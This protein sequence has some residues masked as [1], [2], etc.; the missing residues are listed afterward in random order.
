MAKEITSL[1][2][3]LADQLKDLYSAETLITKALPKLAKAA[4]S[5]DLKNGFKHHLLQTR[6]H[7]ARIKS[8]C[9]S[10][11]VKPTGK[12]CQA[13]VGLV[14][15]GEEAISEDATPEMKDLM[16]IAAA[17]RVEHYEMSGYTSACDLAKA[18]G[19]TAVLKTLS[20]TLSEE[21]ATDATLAKASIPATA[22]ALSAEKSEAAPKKTDSVEEVGKAIKKVVKKI[23]G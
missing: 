1:H 16:L 11:K 21:E 6:E 17:R 18:L 7:V 20:T 2:E 13:T 4:T 8:I 14:K 15:E 12:T 9:A 5:P 23:T 3:V 19:L 10:L 22:K